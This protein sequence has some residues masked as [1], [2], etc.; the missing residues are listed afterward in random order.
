MMTAQ[1]RR[2]RTEDERIQ[3]L[4]EEIAR[5]KARKEAKESLAHREVQKILKKIDK[6]SELAREEGDSKLEAALVKCQSLL[7][8]N[9]KSGGGARVRRTQAEIEEMK[10]QILDFVRLNPECTMGQLSAELDAEAK[11]LRGPLNELL[12]EGELVKQGQRR[13]TRYSSGATSR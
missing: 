1:K 9:G 12:E 6:V 8:A 10:G 5:L 7:V 13:G 2:R 4:Q 11:D 3:A